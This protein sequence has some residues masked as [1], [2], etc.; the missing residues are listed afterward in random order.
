MKTPVA[1][2]SAALLFAGVLAAYEWQQQR[3]ERV[4]FREH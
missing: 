4:H 3:D 2:L 1:A